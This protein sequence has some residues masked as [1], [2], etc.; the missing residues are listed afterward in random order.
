M[1][2]ELFVS[3]SLYDAN[4]NTTIQRLPDDPD[5]ELDIF[6]PREAW[7]GEIHRVPKMKKIRFMFGS[8]DSEYY[9]DYK[10]H[11]EIIFFSNFWLFE[12]IRDLNIEDVRDTE[13][14]FKRLGIAMT[15]YP[16]MHR[17]ILYKYLDKYDILDQCYYSWVTPFGEKG[18]IHNGNY[19]WENE[20]IKKTLPSQ[21]DISS[22]VSTNFEFKTPIEYKKSF[23]DIVSETSQN[24][25]FITEKSWRP[26]IFGKP[27][28]INGA[29]GIH[30]SLQ[31]M[32]FLLYDE[33]F[34]YS[35]DS[36]DNLEDRVKEL[37]YQIDSIK[38]EDYE[39]LWDKIYYKL[40]YNQQLAFTMVKNEI[41]V[42]KIEDKF[43]LWEW[44][45]SAS[46]KRLL[47]IEDKI[48]I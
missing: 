38:D 42:P 9:D 33:I 18:Y 41:G 46:K 4:T 7:C 16:K 31:K 13:F 10:K 22:K 15:N 45:V 34:D 47:E 24:I 6:I 25:I 44:I 5:Y 43:R 19:I 35:F 14:E 26:I 11:G 37:T 28:I 36:I 1:T 40:R 32:G 29:K 27:F 12:H 3:M 20:D 21:S 30:Q 8:C 48:S 39:E 23:L 17:R 2:D